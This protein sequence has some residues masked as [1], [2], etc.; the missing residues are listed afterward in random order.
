LSNQ[1]ASGARSRNA[2]VVGVILLGMAGLA[3]WAAHNRMAARRTTPAESS[4]SAASIQA[5]ASATPSASVEASAPPVPAQ[6]HHLI[7]TEVRPLKSAAE[8]ERYLALLEQ[9]ARER[10]RVSALEVEPGLEAIRENT[11]QIGP[12]S[13]LQLSVTFSEKMKNLG[14][15]LNTTHPETP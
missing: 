7:E 6:L 15:T 9:R 2:A 14:K 4:A 1:Q 13:A 10:G 11:D 12:A 3:Y 5:A 8:V